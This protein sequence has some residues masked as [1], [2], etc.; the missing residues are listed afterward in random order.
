MLCGQL[1]TCNDN[2]LISDRLDTAGGIR[3]T[4]PPVIVSGFEL[5]DLGTKLKL[6]WLPNVER[7]QHHA[8]LRHY[9]HQSLVKVIIKEVRNSGLFC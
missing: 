4:L 2:H 3:T 7:R 9:H 8:V 5:V 1:L 6:N